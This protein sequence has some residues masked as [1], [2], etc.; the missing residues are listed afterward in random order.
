MILY[1]PFR[2]MRLFWQSLVFHI[3]KF[4]RTKQFLS[5][6]WCFSV[7]VLL[8]L[9][10]QWISA[11]GAA[12]SFP[13]D[14]SVWQRR[15][16]CFRGDCPYNA[17]SPDWPTYP[18]FLPSIAPGQYIAVPLHHAFCSDIQVRAR[19]CS[20]GTMSVELQSRPVLWKYAFRIIGI[21]WSLF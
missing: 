19:A 20:A 5:V 17:K 18:T 15:L 13:E 9:P 2:A 4:K 1:S 10:Y 12:L 6:F 21:L 8:L 16:T 3:N 11:Y 7:S 14:V